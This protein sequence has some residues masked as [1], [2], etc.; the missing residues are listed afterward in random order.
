[1]VI[2]LGEPDTV[3]LAEGTRRPSV[4][5]SDCRTQGPKELKGI[6]APARAWMA[7][8]ATP[9]E[10]HFEALRTGDLT[11]LVGSARL[12]IDTGYVVR[13][14]RFR[15]HDLVKFG[16]RDIVELQCRLLERQVVV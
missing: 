15:I 5:S 10:G 13:G 3:V 14:H 11:A 16:R 12:F 4:T 7:L 6:T 1:M 2:W 8:R 9:V